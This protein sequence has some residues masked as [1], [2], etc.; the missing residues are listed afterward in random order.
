MPILNYLQG[1]ERLRKAYWLLG[2]VGV[3]YNFIVRMAAGVGAFD[4]SVAVTLV[5]LYGLYA[6]VAIWN[7]AANV[8]NPIWGQLARLTVVLGLIGVAFEI[9]LVA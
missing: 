3:A 6:A 4:E 9:Y 1:R 5:A 8:D 2:A 7:C